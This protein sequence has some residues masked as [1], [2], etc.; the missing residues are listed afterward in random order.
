MQNVKI[1]YCKNRSTCHRVRNFPKVKARKIFFTFPSRIITT[2]NNRR[3]LKI[4]TN[5]LHNTYATIEIQKHTFVKLNSKKLP[6]FFQTN[7]LETIL[8][9]PYLKEIPFYLPTMRISWYLSSAVI[10][11][12]IILARYA[13][14]QLWSCKFSILFQLYSW[15]FP[16]CCRLVKNETDVKGI[17]NNKY[18]FSHSVFLPRWIQEETYYLYNNNSPH[19]IFR[20]LFFSISWTAKIFKWENQ[21]T[22]TLILTI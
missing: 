11:I 4:P 19:R 7:V 1:C 20:N 5:K 6:V 8:F 10:I 15:I 14:Q 3:F 22:V 13:I 9:Q 18:I 21:Y 17:T 2:A 12:P 16:F